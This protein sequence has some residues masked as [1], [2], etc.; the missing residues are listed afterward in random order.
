MTT[1]DLGATADIHNRAT[2]LSDLI[3]KPA[4][5]RFVPRFARKA[6]YAYSR[7]IISHRSPVLS[8]SHQQANQR[9]RSGK[10]RDAQP[11]ENLPK[12]IARRKIGC[13]IK[14]NRGCAI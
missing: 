14:Q 7:E 3:K 11:L 2:P 9:R 5:A 13:A 4:I 10:G 8:S 1:D 6:E 12:P